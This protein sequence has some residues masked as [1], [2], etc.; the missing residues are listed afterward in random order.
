MIIDS[1]THLFPREYVKALKEFGSPLRQELGAKFVEP[2][3]RLKDMRESGIDRQVIS[4]TVPGVDTVK[5]RESTKLAKIVNDR[6]ANIAEKDNKFV[7]LASLPMLNPRDAVDELRRATDNLGLKGIA[8]LSNIAGKPLD[9]KEFWPIYEQASRMRIPLF[10]HPTFPTHE[11]NFQA[12]SLT[13]VLGF[14]FETSTAATRLVLSGLLDKMPD[15][16]IVLAHLGGTIPYLVSR[17]DEGYRMFPACRQNIAK[18]PST[19]LKTMFLDTVS[20]YAPALNCAYRSWGADKLLLGSDYP[21][22]WV[23]NLKRSVT[24]IEA[25]D[26]SNE[27]KLKIT[28]QN[29]MKLL[30]IQ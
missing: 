13:S 14:P 29:I 20:F 17:I 12:Y 25:L 30:K 26:I 8:L 3:N 18:T 22:D 19:Y 9:R 11:E 16:I 10:I 1:H 5:S 4:I 21:Y 27:E 24:T 15:L 2:E 7:S 23:G 6:L 28:S